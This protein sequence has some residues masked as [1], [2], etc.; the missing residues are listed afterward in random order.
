M[1]VN[2][3]CCPMIFTPE[4]RMALFCFPSMEH[5]ERWW[6]DPVYQQVSDVRRKY[7]NLKYIARLESLD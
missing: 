6:S 1:R 3:S 5:A 7:G 4:G 2:V